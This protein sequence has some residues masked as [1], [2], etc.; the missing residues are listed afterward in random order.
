MITTRTPPTIAYGPNETHRPE[1]QPGEADGDHCDPS[2][3]GR[4]WGGQSSGQ[5]YGQDTE[6]ERP[7]Y[8]GERER[9]SG[10]VSRSLD[11]VDNRE[12]GH[13]RPAEVQE[14]RNL[15]LPA[16]KVGL[17]PEWPPGHRP[18]KGPRDRAAEDGSVLPMGL[19]A[20]R[21]GLRSGARAEGDLAG[22][23]PEMFR[24]ESSTGPVLDRF[25]PDP[26]LSCSPA[27]TGFRS[28]GTSCGRGLT[29]CR[30]GARAAPQGTG[31][32]GRSRQRPRSWRRTRAGTRVPGRRT[33]RG[34]RVLTARRAGSLRRAGP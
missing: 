27:R 5:P 32:G 25:P 26:G 13:W 15:D 21:Q 22:L 34:P 7:G 9:D 33:G 31:R 28:L 6:E 10:L 23:S 1:L 29:R 20:E 2:L 19:V 3:R 16:E 4:G 30:D 18:V 17:P 12:P 14:A 8:Q 24:E 11:R